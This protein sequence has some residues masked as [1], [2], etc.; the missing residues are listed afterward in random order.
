MYVYLAIAQLVFVHISIK[1]YS[2][3]STCACNELL[4]NIL[5]KVCEYN[6]LYNV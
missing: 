2:F 1:F 4:L 6:A 5:C 3:K